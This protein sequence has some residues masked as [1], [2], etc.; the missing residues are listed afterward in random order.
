MTV[1]YDTPPWYSR[2]PFRDC[3]EEERK[4]SGFLFAVD[5]KLSPMV[6]AEQQNPLGR[7]WPQI[8]L[9]QM[10]FKTLPE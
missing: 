1:N 4:N 6:T 7:D 9:S 10:I 2:T 5:Q 3:R 8:D